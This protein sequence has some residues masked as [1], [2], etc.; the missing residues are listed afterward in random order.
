MCRLF[1]L[2]GLKVV[3]SVSGSTLRKARRQTS[4]LTIGM[5]YCYLSE[6]SKFYLITFHICYD[7]LSIS[8]RIEGKLCFLGVVPDQTYR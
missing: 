5:I 4:T 7:G 6:K 3:K 1:I 8:I 2:C